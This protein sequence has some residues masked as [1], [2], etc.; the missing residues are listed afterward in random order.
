VKLHLGSPNGR[1]Q[2]SQEIRENHMATAKPAK[3]ATKLQST[4]IEKKAP[5]LAIR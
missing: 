4:K 1:H 5:L 3:K 2:N